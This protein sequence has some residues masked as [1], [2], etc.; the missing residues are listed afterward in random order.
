MGH[1][2]IV[3]FNPYH[4]TTSAVNLILHL[5]KLRHKKLNNLPKVT[6]LVRGLSRIKT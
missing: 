5:R 1:T 4:N 6:Q 3:S 2:S